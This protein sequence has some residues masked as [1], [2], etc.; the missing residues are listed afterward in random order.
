M[1]SESNFRPKRFS[2]TSLIR[3]S[4]TDQHANVSIRRMFLSM[5]ILAVKPSDLTR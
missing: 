2:E 4:Y 3:V 5:L 1:T